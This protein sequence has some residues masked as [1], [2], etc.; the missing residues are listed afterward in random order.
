MCPKK[1]C[2]T[3]SLYPLSLAIPKSCDPFRIKEGTICNLKIFPH[4]LCITSTNS[5]FIFCY[6]QLSL[7]YKKKIPIAHSGGERI[8]TLETGKRVGV[9]KPSFPPDKQTNKQTHIHTHTHIHAHIHTHHHHHTTPHHTTPH[10]Q[11]KLKHIKRQSRRRPKKK[12]TENRNST[13]QS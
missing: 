2:N 11:M 4:L 8:W 6:L 7:L 9:G 13:S 1:H 10:Q 5:I 3:L 12:N